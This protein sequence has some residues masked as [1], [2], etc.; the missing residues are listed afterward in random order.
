M[1]DAGGFRL[2]E[3]NLILVGTLTWE[4]ELVFS[5]IDRVRGALY[6]RNAPFTTA[7]TIAIE[8]VEEPHDGS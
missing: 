4:R 6:G 3:T 8:A 1:R 5:Q 7:M 2:K